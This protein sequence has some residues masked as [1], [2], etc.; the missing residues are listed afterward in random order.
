MTPFFQ[1]SRRSLAY[2]FAVNVAALVPPV[3]NFKKILLH[4]QPCFDQYSSSLDPNFSKFSFLRPPFFKENP[5]PR[6]YILKP[7]WH[8]STKK[9]WVPPGVFDTPRKVFLIHPKLNY[10]FH[11]PLLEDLTL[12]VSLPKGFNL[13]ALHRQ[14]DKVSIHLRSGGRGYFLTRRIQAFPPPKVI[15][16]GNLQHMWHF[17][18]HKVGK[19]KTGTRFLQG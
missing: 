18:S 10:L 8:T 19:S 1:A 5:F 9:S 4:F 14:L 7:T 6:P 3:F 11:I 12:H 15:P 13:G 16:M 17:N 2:Q